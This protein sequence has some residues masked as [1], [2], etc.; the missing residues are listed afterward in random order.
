MSADE[1]PRPRDSDLRQVAHR[2]GGRPG[3]KLWRILV[4]LQKHRDA[5]R[6][7][8]AR[9]GGG[10]PRGARDRFTSPL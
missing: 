6:E 2:H 8:P 10:P 1:I 5:D 9:G 4:E 7:T 3:T